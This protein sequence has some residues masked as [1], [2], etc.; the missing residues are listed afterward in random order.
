MTTSTAPLAVTPM[1]SRL[2]NWRARAEATWLLHSRAVILDVET[3]GLHGRVCEIAVIDTSG[4][5]LLDTLVDPQT[6]VPADAARVHGINDQDLAGA[7]TWPQIADQVE[8][9]LRRRTVIAYNSPF[10]RD[11][12]RAEQDRVGRPT[13]RRWWCLM[14]ARAAVESAPWRALHGGH[15]AAGDCQ[16]ALRVLQEIA[17]GYDHHRTQTG[18]PGGDVSAG[19]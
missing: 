12:V 16:A 14:R 6:P 5:V 17:V 19:S 4:T 3:T 10:D 8:H 11:R 2:R 18:R 15:R 7:P 9:L 1:R 13:P